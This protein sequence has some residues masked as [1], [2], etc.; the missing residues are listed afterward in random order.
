[1]ATMLAEFPGDARAADLPVGGVPSTVRRAQAGD[2]AAFE[3]LYRDNVN[4]VY[5][6]CLRIS[7]D[8]GRAE[9]LTQDVFVRA[10]QKLASFEGKSAFS[11]WLHRLAVNVVLGDRRSE[12]VRVARVFATDQPEVWERPSTKAADPGTGIDLE[13]AIAQLPPGARSVFVLHDVE[14]YRHEEIARMHGSAVGT[15]KAQL[16]RARRLLREALGR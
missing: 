12:K 15:C 5:A 1:M 6:L 3:Q 2:A 4:R 8:A 9:E 16:H 14:G 7:G 10:W 13:R 11:T